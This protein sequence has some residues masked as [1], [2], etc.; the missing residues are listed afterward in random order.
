MSKINNTGTGKD[1]N[2]G[3][4]AGDYAL[5]LCGVATEKI[6][7]RDT[8]MAQVQVIDWGDWEEN[9]S[10]DRDDWF[11]TSVGARQLL[12]ALR[13][14]KASA[15]AESISNN[16]VFH[17]SLAIEN[18]PVLDQNRQ[19]IQGQTYPA[20][21]WSGSHKPVFSMKTATVVEDTNKKQ[22]S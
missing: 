22:R 12:K 8:D 1:V 14:A 17:L 13:L 7:G 3:I 9:P 20:K 18:V 19:P 2:V 15:Q 16:E 11:N 21:R 10:A 4:I 6:E 5:H